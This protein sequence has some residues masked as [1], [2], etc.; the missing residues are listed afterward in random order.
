M[1]PELKHRLI[2]AAVV[3]ALATIFIPMLFD[4][5]VDNRGQLVSEQLSIPAVPIKSPEVSANRLPTPANK[6]TKPT[7]EKPASGEEEPTDSVADAEIV[8]DADAEANGE[9]PVNEST[10]TQADAENVATAE[11]LPVAEEEP[12]PLDTGVVPE[13][14][15]SVKKPIIKPV[16]PIEADV[17]AEA[18]LKPVVKKPEANTAK[19]L[20]VTKP[21]ETVA[22][23]KPIVK[24]P[25]I[26]VVK[27]V[28]TAKPENPAVTTPEKAAKPELVRWTILAGSF[29]QKDHATTLMKSLRQQ[30][31]P[32]IIETTQSAKGTIYR[33][34]VGPELDKKKA[35]ANKAKLDKQKVDNVLISE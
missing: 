27:P 19:L 17:E 18:K 34:K 20:P 10:Q 12:E 13:A 31:I 1:N 7:T 33:L 35:E 30:G 28:T 8:D 4:D 5:P 9:P 23:V 32:V 11:Q 3:T 2:G 26:H 25:E 16:K 6:T 15:S 22:V 14:K 24:K 21:V 29:G